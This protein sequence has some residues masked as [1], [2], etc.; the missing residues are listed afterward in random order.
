MLKIELDTEKQMNQ[1]KQ[2][3]ITELREE[4]HELCEL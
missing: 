2:K 4:L 3:E 1:D